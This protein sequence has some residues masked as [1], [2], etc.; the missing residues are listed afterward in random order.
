MESF[1]CQETRV[2]LKANYLLLCHQIKHKSVLFGLA[3]MTLVQNEPFARYWPVACLY[4]RY[5]LYNRATNRKKDRFIP[6]LV[7]V[8]LVCFASPKPT[9][10]GSM[11]SSVGILDSLCASLVWITNKKQ[12]QETPNPLGLLKSDTHKK[13]PIGHYL[14]HHQTQNR[15]FLEVLY[16]QPT[17]VLICWRMPHSLLL[18]LKHRKK[19]AFPLDTHQDSI[20]PTQKTKFIVK[21]HEMTVYI[22]QIQT[23]D[24]VFH[25]NTNQ[26]RILGLHP[27]SVYRIKMKL[28]CFESVELMVKTLKEWHFC[29]PRSVEPVLVSA[30]ALAAESDTSKHQID[31]LESEI[32]DLSQNV[33]QSQD[34]NTALEDLIKKSEKEQKS[35]KR[36]LLLYEKRLQQPRQMDRTVFAS[37]EQK[38]RERDQMKVENE[39]CA[40]LVH[41]LN[42]KVQDLLNRQTMEHQQDYQSLKAQVHQRRKAV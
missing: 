19:Q 3:L 13:K 29:I 15:F 1:H 27:E 24:L 33:T 39:K 35:L 20:L 37:V 36:E 34:R 38:R 17:E 8:V 28:S 5:T 30:I 32:D 12:S 2:N 25:M 4:S 6:I 21:P 9:I 7:L 23:N 41:E 11:A 31:D 26:V 18:S 40:R 42:D 22:N 10:V 16:L 14:N